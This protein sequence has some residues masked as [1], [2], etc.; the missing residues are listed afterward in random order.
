MPEAQDIPQKPS[1]A[2][3]VP[4][5]V[6]LPLDTALQTLL[7]EQYVVGD[8]SFATSGTVQANHVISQDPPAGTETPYGSQVDLVISLGVP[9]C[10]T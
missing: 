6:A 2:M 10:G 9:R 4:D 8:V 1:S 7:D 3:L 5:V